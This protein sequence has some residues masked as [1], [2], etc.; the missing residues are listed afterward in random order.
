MICFDI[1]DSESFRNVE[2]W[3]EEVIR[4]CPENTPVFLVGTKADLQSK[5][6]I[7]YETIKAFAE[8]K[9]LSY[10]ETSSKTKENI[11][12]CFINFT[13]TLV[14]HTNEREL[15]YKKKANEDRL[16]IGTKPVP[17]RNTGC[18]GSSTCVI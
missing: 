11:E 17:S 10:L 9:H 14:Q 4:Y 2:N 1:T 5:R 3:L 8:Q 13:R 18:F 7:K 15:Y 16:K 12:N 6:M